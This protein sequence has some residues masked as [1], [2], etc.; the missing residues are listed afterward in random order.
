MI[1]V[2]GF[3]GETT[4]AMQ[5]AADDAALVVGGRRHLDALDVPEDKRVVLG[6][7]APAIEAEIKLA[8]TVV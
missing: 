3:I 8:I 2:F 4:P 5:A 6:R 7:I 1:R